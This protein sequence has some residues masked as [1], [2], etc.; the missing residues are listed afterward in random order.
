MVL[1]GL[2]PEQVNLGLLCPLLVKQNE[3]NTICEMDKDPVES[4]YF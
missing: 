1:S 2:G 4:V 3:T